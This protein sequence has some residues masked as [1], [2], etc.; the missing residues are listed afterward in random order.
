MCDQ[1]A[2]K[3]DFQY[4]VGVASKMRENIYWRIWELFAQGNMMVA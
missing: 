1:L 2:R 4:L 3:L